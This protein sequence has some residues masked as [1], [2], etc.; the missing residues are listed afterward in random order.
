MERLIKKGKI[1]PKRAD[2]IKNS[3]LGIGFEKLD[4]DVFDPEKAYDKLSEIGVKWVRIQSGWQRTEKEKG[5][6]DFEWLDKI[7]DNLIERGL[8]PW[9]CLCYGNELYD[10]LAKTVFGAVGCP[11]IYTQEQKDAWKNYVKTVVKRYKG[12]IDHYEIWN[13][14]DGVHCWKKGVNAKE[15][16]EF[17]IDTAKAIKETDSDAKIIGGAVYGLNLNFINKAFFTGMGDYIDYLSYH[18][19]THDETP[20][21]NWVNSLNAIIARYNPKIKVIQGESGAQ[22]KSNGNGALKKGAWTDEKQAKQL[23]RHIVA[24]LMSGVYFTSYFSCMDMI[25]ALKGEKGK[26][27]TYLDYGYFGVLGAEFDENGRS[28][29][30]YYRK[31]SFYALQNIASV[32]SEEFEPCC[33]PMEYWPDYYTE[34]SPGIFDYDL[35]PNNIIFGGFSKENSEAFVYWYPSNIM[36]TSYEGTITMKL[37]SKYEKVQ[38]VDL[39]EGTIYDIPESILTIDEEGVCFFKNL[40]I[41]DTP[42]LITF[43]EFV[44]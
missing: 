3:K 6:Y 9:M 12:K 5:I 15:Y 20:V 22:S 28:V 34:L 11:P 25:E 43:G 41:K 39:M 17:A 1:I 42:M 32:F 40:P 31:P 44:K 8:R 19:Y 33:I 14:P 21:F 16:G 4:R 35:K 2:E 10:D 18:S 37:S 24:D 23:T 27:A 36:T 7:V 29:G 26:V 38:L 13:E 30:T